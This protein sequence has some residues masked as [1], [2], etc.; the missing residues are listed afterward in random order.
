VEEFYLGRWVTPYV[1]EAYEYL[2]SEAAK[3]H[4]G[5]WMAKPDTPQQQVGPDENEKGNIR[6]ES[7]ISHGMFFIIYPAEACCFSEPL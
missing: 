3:V 4:S 6:L 7:F 2:Q 1:R 5:T